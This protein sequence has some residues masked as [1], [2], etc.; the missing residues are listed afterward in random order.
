MGFLEDILLGSIAK[1]VNV[2]AFEKMWS[3]CDHATPLFL[4]FTPHIS[5]PSMQKPT[6]VFINLSL[7][8]CIVILATLALS[9]GV[10]PDVVPHLIV[11]ALFALGLIAS[12]NW[13]VYNSMHCNAMQCTPTHSY[14]CRRCRYR[15]VSQTG[16]VSSDA[17]RKEIFG[18]RQEET[19]EKKID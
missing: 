17:Q 11:V 14:Y 15:V 1:G 9:G 16:T 13:Y 3:A 4:R 8:A 2:C 12:V 19:I 7:L 5:F 18:D 6:I 10:P